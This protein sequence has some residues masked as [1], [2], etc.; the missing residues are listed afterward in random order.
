MDPKVK[1]QKRIRRHQRVRAKIYGT[2][3]CPRLSIFRSNRHLH[4]QLIDDSIGKTLASASTL[5]LSQK[6]QAERAAA[7][8]RILA[9]EAQKLG[10]N[11]A[12]FDR[13][14]YKYHGQVKKVAESLRESG[15]KI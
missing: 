10:I 15:L 11:K 3:N 14:G 2:K 6:D 4:L 5:K 9:R 12:V 8:A 7:I 1:R 13:G